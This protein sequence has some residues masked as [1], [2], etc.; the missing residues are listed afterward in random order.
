MATVKC[1]RDSPKRV[2]TMV[3]RSRAVKYQRQPLE[4]PD[5]AGSNCPNKD[6]SAGAPSERAILALVLGVAGFF[7][8]S[9]FTPVPAIFIGWTELK[10]IKDKQS[11]KFGTWCAMT[12]FAVG[13]LTTVVHIGG[14]GFWILMFLLAAASDPY[15]GY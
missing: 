12:G 5:S 13:I 15:S 1:R 10:S 2:C 3:S 6:S 7:C 4:S 11:E 9:V 14:L 8:C